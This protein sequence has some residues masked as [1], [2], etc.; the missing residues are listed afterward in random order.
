MIVERIKGGIASFRR[1]KGTWGRR[2]VLRP[3]Q[4]ERARRMIQDEDA[5]LGEVARMFGVSKSSVWRAVNRR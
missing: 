4:I 2:R 3:H 5:S 1:D